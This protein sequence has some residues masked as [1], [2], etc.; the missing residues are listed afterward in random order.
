MHTTLILYASLSHLES[1]QLD[2]IKNPR[3]LRLLEDLMSINFRVEHVS[4]K[5]NV[6]ADYLSRLLSSECD[7]QE[8]PRLLRTYKSSAGMVRVVTDPDEYDYDLL[9]LA[10]QAKED[11]EYIA[12]IK[13][14]QEKTIPPITQQIDLTSYKSVL[15]N[16]SLENTPA[17]QLVILEGCRVVIPLLARQSI[18]VILH[19]YHSS[20]QSMIRLAKTCIYWPTMK[21]DLLKLFESCTKCQINRN[22][23]LPPPPVQTLDFASLSPMDALNVDF[24]QYQGK[25]FIVA[26]DRCS[27]FIMASPTNNQ[28][29]ETALQF[30]H[31]IGAIYGYPTE[32]RTDDGPSFREAFTKELNRFGIF[33][34]KSAPYCPS[35]NG[36]AERAVQSIKNYLSKLGALQQ[37]KLQELLYRINNVPSVIDGAK[38]AFMR[39]F[40]RKGRVT[41][42][43]SLKKSMSNAEIRLA[44]IAREHHQNKL[45]IAKCRTDPTI[46]NIGDK[47]RVRSPSTGKWG[48][49]AQII[50]LVL[51]QDNIARSYLVK[52]KDTGGQYYRH[53]SYLR[54][55][56]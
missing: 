49:E 44:R 43:P 37:N 40:G 50:S 34:K 8:Y 6:V 45:S 33:H 16:L 36:L 47:V 31:K 14:V 53:S 27:G 5:N 56:K 30:I 46:F 7:A 28:S 21:N 20:G 17:G 55:I 26:A 23:K 1:V 51:G 13:A 32:L 48:Q 3:V 11:A 9:K 52:F 18:L 4:A 38:S 39:F 15:D 25:Y 2:S 42:I 12:L 41:S 10:T 29:T 22:S 24:A 54:L 35:G 19:E